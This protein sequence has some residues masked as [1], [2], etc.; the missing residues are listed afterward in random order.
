MREMRAEM[1]AGFR[2]VRDEIRDVRDE[3]RGVRGEMHAEVR[4][5][6]G[7]LAQVKLFMLGGLITILTAFVALHG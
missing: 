1:R 5:V 4:D 7:D 2:D 6:C 3:I